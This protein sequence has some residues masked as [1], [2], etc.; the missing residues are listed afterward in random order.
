MTK[1]EHAQKFPLSYTAFRLEQ[2]NERVMV[3]SESI[4]DLEAYAAG[5]YLRWYLK[6]SKVEEKLAIAIEALEYYADANNYDR[7]ECECTH[8]ASEA[9]KKLKS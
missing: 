3:G 1:Q 8:I 9:L 6:K 7:K 5:D 2:D 4:E